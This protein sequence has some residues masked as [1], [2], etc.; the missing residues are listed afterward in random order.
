MRWV[1]FMFPNVLYE[2]PQEFKAGFPED[3]GVDHGGRAFQGELTAIW[4]VR[5]SEGLLRALDG[6]H[7]P[8]LH[9]ELALG[10]DEKFKCPCHGSGLLTNGHQRSRARR[11]RPLERYKISLGRGRVK[12]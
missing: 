10:S 5:E 6:L 8:R 2:P 4:I 9:A 7:P 11:P 12:S 3:F 1:R